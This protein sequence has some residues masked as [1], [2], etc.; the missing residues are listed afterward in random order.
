MASDFTILGSIPT[1]HHAEAAQFDRVLK[2]FSDSAD[3]IG[4][5]CTV[6]L[7]Y[8]F[9]HAAGQ[10]IDGDTDWKGEMDLLLF[11]EHKMVVYELKGFRA[12]VIYGRTDG[13]PWTIR[14]A[15]STKRELVKSFFLQASKERAFLQRDFLPAFDQRHP[16][17]AG[18]HWLVDARVVLKAGSDL[19]GFFYKLP[20]TETP[21]DLETNVL[22]KLPREEDRAF[23][24][25]A[26]SGREEMTGKLQRIKLSPQD[27][28]RLNS[29]YRQNG[30]VPRTQKWFRILTEDML[31]QDQ[32]RLGSDRF[33]LSRQTADEIIIELLASC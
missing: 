6:V 33:T 9:V 26:F 11:S 29:L 16:E 17:L 2:A 4:P 12:Q 10:L 22:S 31:L 7:N 25:H 5:W 32:P 21:E 27:Y 19:S 14:R 3:Q 13:I 28:G 1:I 8:R 18:N 15:A 20:L 23:V 30:I 24:E